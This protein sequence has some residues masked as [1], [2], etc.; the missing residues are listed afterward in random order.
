MDMVLP[1]ASGNVV[2]AIWGMVDGS[3]E[4]V[5]L[6][7]KLLRDPSVYSIGLVVYSNHLCR[8]DYLSS[9]LPYDILKFVYVV[10]ESNKIDNKKIFLWPLGIQ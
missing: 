5:L 4:N 10:F 9:I 3:R 8:D 1:I 2:M 7:Q 6:V